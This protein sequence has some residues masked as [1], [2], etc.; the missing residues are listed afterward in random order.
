MAKT[1]SNEADVVHHFK[2]LLEDATGAH[3]QTLSS[4]KGEKSTWATDGVIE[5]DSPTKTSVRVLLETKFGTDLTREQVRSNVLAQ[6]LYY[7]KRFDGR[8]EDIPNVILIG[9]QDHCFVIGYDAVKEF[10]SA[11]V[12]WSR[13]PSSPDPKL[14]VEVDVHL[15]RTLAVDGVKMKEICEQLAE[16]CVVKVKPSPENISAMYQHW[17]TH[18]IPEGKYE[19][20]EMTDIFFG[21]VLYSESDDHYAVVHPKKKDTLLMGGKEYHVKV[22]AMNGFFERRQRGLSAKDGKAHG[23][24]GGI[25]TPVKTLTHLLIDLLSDSSHTLKGDLR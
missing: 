21:C 6:A 2:S 20:V 3:F 4:N 8:G 12:D 11:E 5:W 10:M 22:S 9:D 14:H 7:C 19:P 16:G 17:V 15:E 24:K 1:F 18:I 23:F 13:R 25:S